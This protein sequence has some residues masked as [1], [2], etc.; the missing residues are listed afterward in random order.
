M[1]NFANRSDAISVLRTDIGAFKAAYK[2]LASDIGEEVDFTYL[3][4]TLTAGAASFVNGDFVG[5]NA[6]YATAAAF[7]ADLV[8]LQEILTLFTGTRRQAL[9]RLSPR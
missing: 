8:L 5:T 1:A 6:D 3:T 9:S 7:Y 2:Q 4:S